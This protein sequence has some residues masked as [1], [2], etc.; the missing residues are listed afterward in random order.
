[1]TFDFDSLLRGLLESYSPSHEE[2]TASTYLSDWMKSA[3]YD[4]AFVDKAGNAVGILGDGPREIVLLGHIDTVPGYID[5][6]VRDGNLYGRG[7]VDA[8]GPLATFAAAAAQAGKQAGWRII[9]V[10]AVEEEAASSKGARYAATQY[11][12]AFCVIGEPSQWDRVTLGYKGRLL[13]DYR[14]T[15]PLTH[16]AKPEPNAIEHAVNYW[17]QVRTEI[18]AINE[19]RDKAFDQ[20][21]GS[22]RSICSSDDGF[23]ETTDMTLGFR[24][25]IDVPPDVLEAQLLTF[26]NGAAI[27]FRGEEV[28]FKAEKNTPLV[29]AFNNA[30]RD[31]GGKPSYVYKTGTS[32]MNAVGPI[33][34]CPIV[35]YG[36][37]DSSLDHTPHEHI[38]LDEY[39]KGIAVLTNLLRSLSAL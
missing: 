13:A 31:A 17:Y 23:Y 3:G 21:F 36:P 32:D 33:W 28:A 9:V 4:Q 29:R 39:H 11:H 20:V 19:G 25:P 14:F 6:E 10:G 5:V 37:G 7:S 35:A 15:R 18:A 2:H 34:N 38:V 27:T 30:I 22:V 26:A 12:P 24:L 16:T 1:M 8:K